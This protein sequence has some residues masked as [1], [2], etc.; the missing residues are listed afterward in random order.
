MK[1]T[2]KAVEQE[3]RTKALMRNKDEAK[4]RHSIRAK[5]TPE[6]RAVSEF[7]ESTLWLLISWKNKETAA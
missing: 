4:S 2:V 7:A 1:V 5:M 3:L 6:Q